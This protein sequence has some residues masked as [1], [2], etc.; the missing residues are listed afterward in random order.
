MVTDPRCAS[1]SSQDSFRVYSYTNNTFPADPGAA[2]SWQGGFLFEPG[3][4]TVFMGDINGSGDDEAILLRKVDNNP[5]AARLIV[6]GNGDDQIISEF[7]SGLPLADDNG[8]LAGAA[9]DIDGDG[10]DEL[11]IIRDTNI[12][13]FPDG[14]N[15]AGFVNYSEFGTNRR[16]IAVGDLDKAGSNAGPRFEASIAKLERNVNY[17]FTTSGTFT[18][19]NGGTDDSIAFFATVDGNPSWLTLLP[20]VG[21]IPGKSSTGLQIK[22]TVDASNLAINQT[23][24]TNIR[25]TSNGTP[26]ATN[27]PLVIP[28]ALTV[29][30]PPFEATP[31]SANA[32]YYPCTGTMPARDLTFYLTGSRGTHLINLR[33]SHSACNERWI[34]RH[35]RH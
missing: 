30:T 31:T 22:Y 28:V 2:G 9:G 33:A 35:E 32:F 7:Q 15:S 27:S 21:T 17:G 1:S 11:I 14:H 12:R 23:H 4:R 26:A 6:R 10:K 3:P 5:T 25:I 20:N 24:S 8:Y 13:W 16:S 19:K 34:S 29:V 18:V